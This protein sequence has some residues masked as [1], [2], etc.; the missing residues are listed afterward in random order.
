MQ[1][2]QSTQNYEMFTKL[3]GNKFSPSLARKLQRSIA[4][5]N[6][7]ELHPIIVNPVL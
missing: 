4:K 2:I 3:K 7:L 1:K 5:D 6:Q